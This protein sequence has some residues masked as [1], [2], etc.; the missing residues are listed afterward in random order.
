MLFQVNEYITVRIAGRFAISLV[1]KWQHES[2]CLSLSPLQGAALPQL[3]EWVCRNCCSI[4]FYEGP[5]KILFALQTL[6]LMSFPI[7]Y[8]SQVYFLLSVLSAMPQSDQ[9][10]AS[11]D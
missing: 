9:V 2:V 10:R 7:K 4:A 1:Y 11:R 5:L 6:E 3:E 8:T